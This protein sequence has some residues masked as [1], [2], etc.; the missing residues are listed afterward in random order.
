MSSSTSIQHKQKDNEDEFTVY[1]NKD[2]KSALQPSAPAAHTST[3]PPS[4]ST[5]DIKGKSSSSAISTVKTGN[6]E[7]KNDKQ[8]ADKGKGVDNSDKVQGQTAEEVGITPIKI[9]GRTKLTH[10]K[11][12]IT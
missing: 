6:Q 4:S 10:R 5:S 1:E 11:P 8:I 7:K 2:P 12:T 9:G 3:A